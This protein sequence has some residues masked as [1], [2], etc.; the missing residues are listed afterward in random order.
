MARTLNHVANKTL[1][2]KTPLKKLTGTKPN[3]SALIIY[4]FWEKIYYKRVNAKFPYESTKC[5]GH[6]VAV[7][8]NVRHAMTFKI[9]SAES[10]IIYRS[11]IRS[12]ENTN[13]R[14]KILEPDLNTEHLK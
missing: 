10:K 5:L 6:Y 8:D 13:V 14:N 7:A 2:W 12:A 11:K 4:R 1:K 9:L 3:I